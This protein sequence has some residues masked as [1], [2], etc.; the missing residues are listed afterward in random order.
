V[1]LSLTNKATIFLHPEYIAAV[2][3]KGLFNKR[4]SR[5]EVI[6]VDNNEES[7]NHS[8]VVEVLA[9]L[10]NKPEWKACN[11]QVVLSGQF[12]KFRIAKWNE[13]LSRE[14]QK[15]LV[16]HQLEEI[17]G[18]DERK[19]QV[20]ISD[21]GFGKSNL[22]FAVEESFYNALLDLE[23][24]HLFK[25]NL[26]VPYFVLIANYWRKSI[27]NTAWI[28]IK[29]SA[30]IYFANTKENSWEMIKTVSVKRGWELEIPRIL[31]REMMQLE[32]SGE[33][34]QI[35]FHEDKQSSFNLDSINSAHQNIVV[36]RR[37]F[38]DASDTKFQFINYL[39]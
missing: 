38:L 4:I 21:S 23:K 13:E 33:I 5:K 10:L 34:N 1:L 3:H 11:A 20:F 27:S 35:Y 14:E 30:Y 32:G 26:I 2:K 9:L 6:A 16:L 36:L 25:L 29:D 24:K 12:T 17:Y 39:P 7:L 28:I 15:I 19:L 22:A 37:N 8:N 18:I 31:E